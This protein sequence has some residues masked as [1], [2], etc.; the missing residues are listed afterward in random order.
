MLIWADGTDGTSSPSPTAIISRIT[1]NFT[2]N[3]LSAVKR[4]A[5]PSDI[6]AECPQNF[7]FFSQCF[8][9]ITF[10]D[11]PANG[12]RP[13]NYT[14][15]ADSGLAFINVISHTSDFEKRILPLQWAIDQVVI[16]SLFNISWLQGLKR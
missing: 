10:A 4:L 3:Q 14:I 5:S 8:A 16:I 1:S 6:P 15:S 7:N 9:A 12:S 2:S 13:I 11:I